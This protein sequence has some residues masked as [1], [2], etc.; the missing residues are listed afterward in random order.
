MDCTGEKS[1]A[2]GS[3]V[4]TVYEG[5]TADDSFRRYG[6]SER[7]YFARMLE[8]KRIGAILTAKLQRDLLPDTK[9]TM[10]L[11]QC[12]SAELVTV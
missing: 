8:K 6:D 12:V 10:G 2:I 5:N 7:Q 4:T 11:F 3:V 1:V 9:S